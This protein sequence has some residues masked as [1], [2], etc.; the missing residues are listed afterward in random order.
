MT[1]FLHLIN[2]NF[3]QP[4]A[5][6]YSGCRNVDGDS[7]PCALPSL[8]PVVEAADPT[9]ETEAIAVR[10][11][12]SAEAEADPEAE[13]FPEADPW[14]Y[15]AQVPSYP[16]HAYYAAPVLPYHLPPA[17][18]YLHSYYDHVGCKNYLGATVPCA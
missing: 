12:R 18:H 17:F 7:V 8:A 5:L 13:A 3:L 11:R 14:F 10:R 9:N 15:Y 6:T 1:W 16:Y 4:A 2:H